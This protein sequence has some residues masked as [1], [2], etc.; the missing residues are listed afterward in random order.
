MV[1]H[2]LHTQ[3]LFHQKRLI[4]IVVR[5]D[6]SSPFV[7]RVHRDSE[8]LRIGGKHCVLAEHR[9]NYSKEEEDHKALGQKCGCSHAQACDVLLSQI[10]RVITVSKSPL[11]V[12]FADGQGDQMAGQDGKVREK[13]ATFLGCT[14]DVGHPVAYLQQRKEEKYA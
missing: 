1:V 7:A 11:D 3:L 2:C 9:L 8:R 14:R 5:K 4:L 13:G 12:K 6:G 10:C